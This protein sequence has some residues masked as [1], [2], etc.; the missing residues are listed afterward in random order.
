[1]IDVMIIVGRM[2]TAIAYLIFNGT[3][4]DEVICHQTGGE[5]CGMKTFY[6]IFC[7]L[8]LTPAMWIRTMKKLYYVSIFGLTVMIFGL[9]VI[10]YYDVIYIRDNA[11]PEREV[12][13]FDLWEVPLFFGIAVFNFN[14]N[15]VTLNV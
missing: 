2:G 8:I 4:I 12:K 6:I 11:F 14:A 3:T 1:M 9:S 13:G 5:V 10:M 15:A 7:V